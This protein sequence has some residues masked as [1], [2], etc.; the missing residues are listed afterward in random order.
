[1]EITWCWV[2][3]L[4]PCNGS[5]AHG[6]WGGASLSDLL[7]PLSLYNYYST[8]SVLIIIQHTGAAAHNSGKRKFKPTR[9]PQLLPTRRSAIN[10]NTLITMTMFNSQASKPND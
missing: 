5:A 1:M 6:E 9:S 10:A 4:Q 2:V 7:Q 8:H 3:V